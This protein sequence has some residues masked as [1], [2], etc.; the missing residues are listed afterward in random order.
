MPNLSIKNVP[1]HVVNKL[2]Q[3]AASHHRS[4]QGELMELICRST[5]E[6]ASETT[7]TDEEGNLSGWLSI[8]EIAA[9]LATAQQRPTRTVPLAVDIIRRDRDSR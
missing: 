1:E 6:A 3:R 9:E 7:N 4:L 2:R 8:E 5:D